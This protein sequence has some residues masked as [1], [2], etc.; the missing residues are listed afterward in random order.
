[1]VLTFEP[2]GGYG[3]PDHIAI[4]QHT[5]EAFH[6]AADPGKFPDQ[7]DPWQA[8]RLYYTAIP[9]SFFIAMRERLVELGDDVSEFERFEEGGGGWPDEQVDVTLDV[10]QWIEAKWS[11]LNCHQTQF[12]SNNLFRRLPDHVAKEMMSWE[13]FALAW[14]ESDRDSALIELFTDLTD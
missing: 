10:S 14:P 5:V 2:N 1:V 11:A 13:Y 6:A 3:H 4:H 7:G 12:G 9:R 8:K